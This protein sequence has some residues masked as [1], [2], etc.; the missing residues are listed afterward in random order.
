[1]NRDFDLITL[2]TNPDPVELAIASDQLKEAGIACH[3]RNQQ[4]GG[5]YGESSMRLQR[6]SEPQLVVT[7]RDAKRAAEILGISVLADFDDEP[8]KRRPGLMGWIRWIIGLD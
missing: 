1:M 6:F 5:L 2:M 7:R 8:R 3:V 4:F